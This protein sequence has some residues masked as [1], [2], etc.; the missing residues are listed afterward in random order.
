[1][2]GRARARIAFTI[3]TPTDAMPMTAAPM[4]PWRHGPMSTPTAATTPATT[5]TAAVDPRWVKVAR[6]AS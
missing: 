4:T 1:M 3:S 6:N 2:S 5:V